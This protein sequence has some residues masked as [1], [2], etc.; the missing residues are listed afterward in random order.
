MYIEY[1]ESSHMSL[2]DHPINQPNFDISTIWT[3]ILVAQ[4]TTLHFR[5]VQIMCANYVF[6]LVS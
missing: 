6:M 1:K 4:V 3:P 5:P 2:V